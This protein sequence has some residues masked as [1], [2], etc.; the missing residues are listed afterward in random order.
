LNYALT[1][2]LFDLAVRTR[3]AATLKVDF[4]WQ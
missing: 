4:L 2:D 1:S 3:V